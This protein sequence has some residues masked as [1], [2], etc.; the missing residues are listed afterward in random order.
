MSVTDTR[1]VWSNLTLSTTFDLL[2]LFLVEV[3]EQKIFQKEE[4]K[5]NWTCKITRVSC[6]VK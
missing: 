4:V 3:Y 5:S 2:G 6:P 1:I